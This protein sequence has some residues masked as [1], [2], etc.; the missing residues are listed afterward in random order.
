[1]NNDFPVDFL[2]FS[3]GAGIMNWK[4][5]QFIYSSHITKN[6]VINVLDTIKPYKL[7]FTVHLPVPDNHHMLF[8]DNNPNHEDLTDYTSYYQEFVKPFS[9]NNIPERA[10]QI[11]VLLNNNI[12]LFDTFTD[13]LKPLKTVLTTSP[14]NH[15]SMWME[16]FN[17]GVSKGN[18]IKKVADYLK[19]NKPHIFSIGND[20]NDIDMLNIADT[21]YVVNNAPDK[22]KKLF[23]ITD[24]N[25]NSGFTKALKELGIV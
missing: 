21:A 10:T 4:T 23:N 2:V 20:F 1:L 14:V 22:L 5:K 17:S 6:D 11:I 8:Y 9:F 13:N 3:S 19:I 25:N 16:V 24:S 18:G 15:K 7:N 12:E